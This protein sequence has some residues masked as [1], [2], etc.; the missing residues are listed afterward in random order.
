MHNTQHIT[1]PDWTQLATR[2]FT[3]EFQNAT[4]MALRDVIRGADGPIRV[5]LRPLL[6]IRRAAL[7]ATGLGRVCLFFDAMA[8]QCA[9]YLQEKIIF[10]IDLHREMQGLE[11]SP[12]DGEPQTR[13]QVLKRALQIFMT[14]KS[15]LHRKHSYALCGLT[16]AAIDFC[17]F[18]TNHDALC[19]QIH[20]MQPF[21]EDFQAFNMDSIFEVCETKMAECESMENSVYRA[22]LIYSRSECLPTPATAAAARRLL[23]SPKFYF[24]AVYL[25]KKSPKEVVC[26]ALRVCPNGRRSPSH[27][28]WRGAGDMQPRATALSGVWPTCGGR[29][30]V[31]CP[32]LMCRQNAQKFTRTPNGFRP[33]TPKPQPDAHTPSAQTGPLPP[34]HRHTPRP[35]GCIGTAVYR[36]RRGGYPPCWTPPPPPPLPMSEADSQNFASVLSGPRG[37]KLRTVRPALGGEDGGTQ[38]GGVSQPTPPPPSSNTSLPVPQDGAVPLATDQRTQRWVPLGDV[39]NRDPSRSATDKGYASPSNALNSRFPGDSSGKEVRR[40]QTLH[41][42]C[43]AMGRTKKGL[44]QV[45][46]RH[47]VVVLS[48]PV[49]GHRSAMVAALQNHRGFL[50]RT[51]NRTTPRHTLS[52]PS[53]EAP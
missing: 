39:H 5:L 43:R 2:W 31:S 53:G 19:R 7:S 6:N 35:K 30:N 27:A 14:C 37:F 22:I 25:H 34:T 44:V 1:I 24:D 29:S 33:K 15:K 17:A 42:L 38:G 45:R 50:N 4:K 51:V 9:Q 20:E 36:R 21:D 41:V 23:N 18:S 47:I 46:P 8:G 28:L 40:P 12:K 48:S 32:P 49:L 11:F 3:G 26:P 13:F 16:E 10:F 52:R